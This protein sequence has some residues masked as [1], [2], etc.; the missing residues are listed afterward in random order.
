MAPGFQEINAFAPV[1]WAQIPDLGLYM[2]QVITFI[3]RIY[4]P[5]YGADMKKYLSPAMINNY[6]KS[7][8]I[9][10]PAGKKYSREQIALLIMIVAL[11]QVSAMEEIRAMLALREDQTA[12]ALYTAFCRRFSEVIHSLRVDDADPLDAA[13]DFAILAS[14]FRAGCAAALN[15]EITAE[16]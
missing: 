14:G 3:G 8:L 15:G 16:S 11:K 2:D 7:R 4:Q 6:V 13:L 9:P 5:L 10:R 12:E 1:S